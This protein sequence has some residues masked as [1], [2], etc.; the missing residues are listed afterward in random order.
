MATRSRTLR[1][2]LVN[3]VMKEV[4]TGTINGGTATGITGIGGGF[5]WADPALSSCPTQ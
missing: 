3:R 5:R 2:D 1:G 4:F